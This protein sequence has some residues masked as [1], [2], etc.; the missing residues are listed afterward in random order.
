MLKW[1]GVRVGLVSA[2]AV[3]GLALAAVPAQATGIPNQVLTLDAQVIWDIGPASGTVDAYD[4][5]TEAGLQYDTNA[6]CLDGACDPPDDFSTQD[7]LVFRV[8]VDPGESLDQVTVGALFAGSLGLG[9]FDNLGGLDPTSGDSTTN[10]NSPEFFFSN[11]GGLTGDSALLFAVYAAG[12]LP[13]A[14]GP[15]GLGATNFDLRFGGTSDQ[16]V[17]NATTV[18]PEPSTALLMGLGLVGFGMARGRNRA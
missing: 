14:G 5:D 3:I 13:T 6:I 7:W 1:L 18:V 12:S 16:F 15:F 9:Y 10:P 17:G 8:T 2:L 11:P 4:P